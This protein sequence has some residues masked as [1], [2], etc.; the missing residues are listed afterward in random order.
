MNEI[1]ETLKPMLPVLPLKSSVLFPF[2]IMPL[3]VGRSSSMAAVEA[4]LG[5]ED[6]TLLI[7]SQNNEPVADPAYEDLFAIGTLA[8]IKKM[9]RTDDVIQI[10]VQGIHRVRL[11][12]DKSE[13]SHVAAEYE[14]I[15]RP[16]DFDTST[17]ALHREILESSEKLLQAVNPQARPT[18]S[19]MIDQLESPLHQVYI[20]SSLLSLSMTEEQRLLAAATQ[21]EAFELVHEFLA[22]ALRILEVRQQISDQAQTEMSREQ[23][24][25]L[26]R[27]Q[28]RAIQE[29]LS[30]RNS[31]QEDVEDLRQQ[32]ESIDLSNEVRGEVERDLARLERLSTASPDHQVTRSYLDLVVELPWQSL[33]PANINLDHAKRILHRDHFGLEVVKD[34]IIEH[35]AIMKLNASAR[36]PILCFVGPPGV[37]KTSLGKSIAEATG[38][39]FARES[40]GGLSDE[41]ELR[42][43]R[44]SYIGAMPGRIIQ[45]VRRVGTR[46][47]VLMLDE[48][49]KL[50]RDFRGDPAATL[51]EVLDPAQNSQFRDNYLNLPFDL[52]DV[53]F[54]ATANALDTIPGPLLDR[55]EVLEV[56]GYSDDEKCQIARRYLLPHQLANAGFEK[57]QLVISDDALMQIAR[58]YTRESGVRNLERV[59][60]QLCRKV[61]TKFATGE[62]QRQH[63]D[64]EQLVVLL[65]HGRYRYEARRQQLEPGVAAGLAWTPAGGSLLY[66]E[67]VLLPESKEFTLTGQLGDVMR[68]SARAAQSCVRSQWAELNLEKQALECGIHLHVPAG[69]TPKD[70]PSAGVTMATAIASLYSHHAVRGDTAMTGEIT[71]SGYVL[72]VGGIREKV[73]AAHRVG[74]RRMILPK[75][76]EP[77]LDDLPNQ[78]RDSFEFILA[79]RV[80]EVL[81]AAI[82]ALE[83][84][85]LK[86]S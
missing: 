82:P 66:V 24:E 50:G 63:I 18:L 31:E 33:S 53:F 71:L 1:Q 76:N 34:R 83:N 84:N 75:A 46:N 32:L 28:M 27:K 12:A 61:A 81:S 13:T 40:L 41:G 77:D 35:L 38:R 30:E 85:F 57:N 65:G 64:T 25:Y 16:Q 19:Q 74:M 17:E 48:I 47:P 26:L 60:A 55:I 20:L 23:R 72:P 56:S 15:Q 29:E 2:Q 78:V 69:A 73:L 79:G 59:I 22:H 44:R 6:K 36:P 54:V 68:E 5:T 7:I 67:A 39:E 9:V 58:Y 10:V 8:V 52:S 43:H 49:D 11:V 3:V 80:D 51:L 45:A 14:E 86:V 21:R 37:G 4:A 70:G 62:T 42:G